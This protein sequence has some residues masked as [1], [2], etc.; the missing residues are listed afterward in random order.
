[1]KKQTFNFKYINN[2]DDFILQIPFCEFIEKIN[3]DD[4]KKHYIID[5][6]NLSKNDIMIIMNNFDNLQTQLLYD[7]YFLQKINII[8]YILHDKKQTPELNFEQ[9]LNDYNFALKKFITEEELDDI[10]KYNR[11]INLPNQ[12]KIEVNYNNK[13]ISIIDGFNLLYGPND[14]GKTAHLKVFATLLECPIFNMKDKNLTLNIDKNNYY[15]QELINRFNLDIKKE[16]LSNIEQYFY[17]LSQIITYCKVNNMPLLLDD[18]SWNSIDAKRKLELINA[19]FEFSKENTTI[20]TACQDDVKKM[21]KRHI[22]KPN[23]NS[24]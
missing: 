7:S 23:I 3:G 2:D 24:L 1:M 15:F 4:F 18:L 13:H 11:N 14:S 12:T 21:I 10:I 8:L 19:L 22:Y 20:V 5:V 17:K 16:Y 9:I 6:R